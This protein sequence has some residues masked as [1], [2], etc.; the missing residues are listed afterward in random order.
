VQILEV[1]YPTDEAPRAYERGSKPVAIDGRTVYV[2]ENR[3]SDT[4]GL[5]WYDGRMSYEIVTTFT[6]DQMFR[7]A[8]SMIDTTPKPPPPLESA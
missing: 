5:E 8:R 2:T 7:I 1:Q 4:I 6:E 3:A